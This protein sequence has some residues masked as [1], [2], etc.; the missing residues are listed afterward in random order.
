MRAADV[1]CLVAQLGCQQYGGDFADLTV[2]GRPTAE[3]QVARFGATKLP[4]NSEK[5][6]VGSQVRPWRQ[7]HKP[8]HE[9]QR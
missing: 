7:G 6:A 4:F 8:L 5:Q 2:A 3:L 1:S 9:L